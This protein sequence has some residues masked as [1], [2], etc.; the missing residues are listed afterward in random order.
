M[1]NDHVD[2]RQEGDIAV[3]AIDRPPLNV[4]SA[5]VRDGIGQALK[6]ASDEPAIRAIV[7]TGTQRVFSAGV[8][9]NEIGEPFRPPTLHDLIRQLDA[10]TKPVVAA[11]GGLA[12]GGGLELALSCHARVGRPNARLGLPEVRLGILPAAGGTQRLPRVVGLEKALS[13]I[14]SGHSIAA[15]EAAQIGPIDKLM[16]GAFPGE[17][18]AFAQ[19]VEPMTRVRDRKVAPVADFDALA[20]RALRGL[21]ALAPRLCAEAVRGATLPFDE[22]L[23]KE[24]RL[25]EQLVE[26]DESRA[27]RHLFF[28]EREAQK[29][30]GGAKPGR[31]VTRAVIIGA[32][33][34]GGGIAMSF[35]NAGIPIT[36]TETDAASLERGLKRIDELYALS[37]RRGSITGDEAASR[38]ARIGGTL[39][40]DAV[41]NA[42]I[43]IEAAFEDMP[44][45]KQI[46]AELDRRAKPDAVL[47][48]NTSY[49]DIDD[50]ASATSRPSGVLGMHFFSPAN[51]M[52]LLEVVRGKDTALDVIATAIGLGKTLGKVP[53]V[54]GNCFGFVGNR[55]LA[56]R[57]EQAERLLLEGVSPE[58][59]DRALTEFG[60]RMGPF[61]MSDLAGLDVGWRARKAFGKSAPVADALC[62]AG[63]FGQKTGAGFYLYDGRDRRPNPAVDEIIAA[64]ATI[65]GITHR[66]IGREEIIERLIYPMINEGARILEEGIATR[67]GDID[68]IWVHGYN[69][70]AWKAGPMWFGSEVGFPLIRD[71]LLTYAERSGDDGLRP[72]PYLGTLAA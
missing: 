20:E 36:I 25:Y 22:G 70:P 47:A 57:T 59:V 4:L 42:D 15:K 61:A 50:I 8:D 10:M 26:G 16:T 33:T 62:E 32:G 48:S 31:R 43:V 6:R 5:R 13:M 23:A 40:L 21:G 71:R 3:I 37:A 18:I 66:T 2:F 68:V 65:R 55:M 58:D 7:V 69:W 56:R 44:I 63:R 28:A 34:M 29:S 12:L 45:K 41:Q 24:W 46:F 9:I 1:I 53:V 11:I 35:A 60:F 54:V 39:G 49:L 17:A 30:P 51:V 19:M 67:P 27:Q 52:K 38:L 14:V 64:Q 72:A